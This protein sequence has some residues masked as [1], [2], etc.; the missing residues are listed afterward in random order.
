MLP[1]I[2]RPYPGTKRRDTRNQRDQ[3]GWP[4]GHHEFG[5]SQQDSR[6]QRQFRTKALE[7]LGEC[8]DDEEIDDNDSHSHR[9][10][11]EH[12]IAQRRFHLFAHEAFELQVFEQAQEY[13]V[14]Q[15]SGFAN[16]HH[17]YIK[18]RKD[19]RMPG[20]RYREFATS[21]QTFAYIANDVLHCRVGCRFLQAVQRPHDGNA[22]LEQGM[23]LARKEQDIDVMNA[24]LEQRHLDVA[25][26]LFRCPGFLYGYRRHT[27]PK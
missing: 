18:G 7:Y 4:P 14:K 24:R 12:R 22:R 6:H 23:N 27:A 9:N 16:A 25:Q 11:D 8:R 20:Q 5:K 1:P 26:P 17:R 13:F 21:L 19:L 2:A 15:A 3:H 10:N